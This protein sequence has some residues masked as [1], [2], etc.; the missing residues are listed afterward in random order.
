MAQRRQFTGIGTDQ[1]AVRPI[2]R[3]SQTGAGRQLD[4]FDQRLAHAPGGAHHSYTSHA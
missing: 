1:R 4:R 3:S 2:D